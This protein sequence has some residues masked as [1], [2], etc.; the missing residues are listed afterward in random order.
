MTTTYTSHLERARTWEI[1]R[2]AA[3]SHRDSD[4]R[5]AYDHG[6]T[7]DDLFRATGLKLTELR[8]ITQEDF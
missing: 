1:K 2:A 5:Q 7:L 8:R 6:A 4:I 3:E